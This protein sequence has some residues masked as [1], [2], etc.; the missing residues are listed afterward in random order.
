MAATDAFLLRLGLDQ[1]ADARTIRRAYACELKQVD[2]AL[3][4]AAFQYLR[5]CYE[6]ALAWAAGRTAA[7]EAARAVPQTAPQAAAQPAPEHAP[8][9]VFAPWPAPESARTPV[10]ESGPQCAQAT[11]TLGQGVFDEFRMRFPELAA[12][13]A[14]SRETAWLDALRAALADERLQNFDARFAFERQLADL[15]ARGWQPGHEDLF[16]VAA[17]LLGWRKDRHT[18]ARLGAAGRV[19]DLAI[20]ERMAFG[21]QDRPLRLRQRDLLV[22]LRAPELPD[23][24]HILHEMV[25]FEQL[26]Q[27]FPH[28]VGVV[29]PV[30]AIGAW[31]EHVRDRGQAVELA[32]T[33]RPASDRPRGLARLKHLLRSDTL[34]LIAVILLIVAALAVQGGLNAQRGRHAPDGASASSTVAPF[35]ARVAAHLHLVEARIADVGTRILYQPGPQAEPGVQRLSLRVYLDQAGR[36]STIERL[37]PAPDPALTEAVETALYATPPFPAHVNRTFVF[38]YAVALERAP[39]AAHGPE[40][41]WIVRP[42][43][44]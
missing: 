2:Q 20:E 8:V 40:A 4:P 34:R 14:E 29:A 9:P 44:A 18:L 42:V 23:Y 36:V 24:R 31:H 32:G 41:G 5:E 33:S 35:P 27:R 19:L 12:A 21:A 39:A 7:A 26:V 3:D 10:P 15:L 25:V 43:Q 1:Q 30:A 22:R 6:A 17:T 13:P 38:E 37:V 28:W 16:P 11:A